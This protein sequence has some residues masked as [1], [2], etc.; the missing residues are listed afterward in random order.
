VFS[1]EY[2]SELNFLQFLL[3]SMG[4]NYFFLFCYFNYILI[5]FI[6]FIYNGV[7][8]FNDFGN[9]YAMY[10]CVSLTIVLVTM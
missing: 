8:Y 7:V 5:I 6:V 10:S 2:F 1:I 9:L 3:P 4:Y